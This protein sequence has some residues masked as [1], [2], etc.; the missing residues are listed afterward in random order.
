MYN[1]DKWNKSVNDFN[2]SYNFLKNNDDF[3]YLW[4]MK[5]IARTS[6]SEWLFSFKLDDNMVRVSADATSELIEN[7]IKYSLDSTLVYVSVS[8]SLNEVKI[9]TRNH[10]ESHD[11]ETIFQFVEKINSQRENLNELYIAS[12]IESVSK[13]KSQLGL[14]K[15][16]LE[17]DG[18]I[19]VNEKD[20]VLSVEVCIPLTKAPH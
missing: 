11:I 3:E 20:T 12:I 16:M 14:I 10:A 1:P 6:L 13:E 5:S 8:V 7:C 17:S 19:E 9:A 2:I 4:R 15:I 18:F